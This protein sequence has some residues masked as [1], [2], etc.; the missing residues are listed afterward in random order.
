MYIV[1]GSKCSEGYP[2]HHYVLCLSVAGSLWLAVLGLY[3]TL[4]G[5]RVVRRR[6]ENPFFH[7]LPGQ[8]SRQA[9]S[10]HQHCTSS[11]GLHN[12]CEQDRTGI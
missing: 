10:A 4:T 3:I 11:W 8:M 12:K 2:I 9:S 6:G 7:P 1:A 5:R